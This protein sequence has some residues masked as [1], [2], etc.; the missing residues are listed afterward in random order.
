MEIA[1]TFWLSHPQRKIKHS[2]SVFGNQAQRLKNP[3]S[4]K[5]HLLFQTILWTFAAKESC[6]YLKTT[7]YP[8]CRSDRVVSTI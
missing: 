6:I 1:N 2:A 5:T 3:Q 8:V 4:D 7:H